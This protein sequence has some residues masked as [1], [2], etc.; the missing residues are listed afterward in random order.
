MKLR[1]CAAAVLSIWLACAFS[2]PGAAFAA[3]KQ[4]AQQAAR[5]R[6]QLRRLQQA[7]QQLTTE[8]AQVVQEKTRLESERNALAEQVK[9]TAT[10]L[11]GAE[12]RSRTVQNDLKRID[13]ESKAL[14]ERLAGLEKQLAETQ[15]KL[16]STEDA[17]VGREADN[18][19]LDGQIAEQRRIMGRQG[20]LVTSCEQNNAK[21]HELNLELL[22]KYR[23][24]GIGAVLL[25]A[26][27][28]TGIKKVEQHNT[29]QE[30]RDKLD[31]EKVAP[32][33]IAEP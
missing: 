15:V 14:K 9:S 13:E 8:K 19:R 1:Q 22:E 5:E 26:E 23:T 24:K 16:R 31:A 29:A 2:M 12:A 3:E 10:K 4:S 7:N 6:E 21:I 28:F 30:L 18:K 25:G 32:R 33:K 11:K 17:L 27:P 20:E